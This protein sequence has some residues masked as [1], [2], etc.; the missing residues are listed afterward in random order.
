MWIR[1]FH[2]RMLGCSREAAGRL[3]DGL[4]SEQDALW[5]RSAWPA[6]RFDRPLQ[7]GAVGGHG[8]IHYR[9]AAY[10]PGLRVVFEFVPPTGL[11]GW[12]GFELA[13]R[14]QEQVALRH[15]MDARPTGWMRLA[16]PIAIRWMHEAVIADALHGAA[17]A[18]GDDA[19]PRPRWS[20]WTRILRS[21][22][23][24]IYGDPARGSARPIAIRLEQLVL[25]S[26]AGTSL[27]AR[28]GA[29]LH[30]RL[31]RLSRGRLPVLGASRILLLSVVGRRTRRVR[32]TPLFYVRDGDRLVVCNVR[33]AAERPNPW[34][35]NV[36]AAGRVS[37]EV[38]G[39][40]RE[41]RARQADDR[42]VA[43][44]WPR[45][46]GLWPPY[47]RHV[48][49]SGSG[50]CSCSSRSDARDGRP[51][52]LGGHRRRRPRRDAAWIPAPGRRRER[53]SG[54]RVR[55]VPASPSW[56]S[57]PW[58]P[59]ETHGAAGIVASPERS[60]TPTSPG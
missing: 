23:I 50:P 34:V 56:D 44:Y 27:I 28:V 35:A 12:H 2:E 25:A 36:R 43:Q 38:D 18:V 3:I 59:A 22:A 21:V 26:R 10:E 5:P 15:L 53:S 37:V 46:V 48:A 60:T 24:A 58:F 17:A 11:R 47:E 4:G 6:M 42:E 16:W 14:G 9:V 57:S 45:F 32:T 13:E 31:Y 20:L 55:R 8:P 30:R 33:P 49:A 1:D 29:P 41:M 39:Q 19:G 7:V 51:T 40:T 54:T 52:R